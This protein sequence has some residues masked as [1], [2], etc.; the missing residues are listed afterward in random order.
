MAHSF[1]AYVD[2]SGDDGLPGHYRAPGHQGGSSNWL[3]LSASLWRY[4]RDLEAVQW[5]DEIR[6]QLPVQ[7]RRKPLHCLNL[8]H[9]QRIMACQSL[10]TRPMRSICVMANKPIIPPNIYTQKNQLYFYMS[11]YLMER[12]S[13]FCRDTRPQV[14]EGDGRVK[15]VF[16]R[17]GG[18]SYDGFRAYL[19]RLKNGDQ[20]GIQIQWNVIDI[21]GIE[22]RDHPAKAGLQIADLVAYCMTAGLEP[23]AYGNCE[24]RYATILKPIIYRRGEKYLSYGVKLVPR[25]DQI[26]LSDQQRALV[27]LF[28]EEARRPPGP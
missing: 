10:A 13:W 14:P 9:Q 24:L 2:E 7:A 26:Q 19:L 12:I 21:E 3:T 17:R 23:D 27:D 1:I 6:N 25:P 20:D 16:S 22:A 4:S 8:N 5:R 11:R 18:L 28:K 15:V